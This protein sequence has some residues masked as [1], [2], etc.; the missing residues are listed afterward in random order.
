MMGRFNSAH[1]TITFLLLTVV[2]TGCPPSA[3]EY[4]SCGFPPVESGLCIASADD[5][6]ELA[7][8]KAASNCVIQ[9]PQCPENFC[10][11]FRGSNGFCSLTCEENEDCPGG[12]SCKEFAF[13][14][15]MDGTPCLLCVKP[16][17]AN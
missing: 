8:K 10:V 7:L 2:L 3:D 15:N 12:G 5:T 17:L 9:Q 4:E 11:S 1:T 16:S 13:D 6:E 14:C